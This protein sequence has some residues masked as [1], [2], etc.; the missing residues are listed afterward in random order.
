MNDDMGDPGSRHAIAS[1]QMIHV[2]GCNKKHPSFHLG[3][4]R[5]IRTASHSQE[6]LLSRCRRTRMDRKATG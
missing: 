6:L 2:L 5:H 3:K 4:P 1:H